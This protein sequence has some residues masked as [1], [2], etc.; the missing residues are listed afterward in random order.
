MTFYVF[1]L[2]HE[3]FK[4]SLKNDCLSRLLMKSKEKEDA[5][6]ITNKIFNFVLLIEK[7]KMSFDFFLIN[8]Q[9]PNVIHFSLKNSSEK[10]F[11]KF[12]VES[13]FICENL[14][15]DGNQSLF[16]YL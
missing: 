3:I 2:N 16:D 1:L 15:Y 11:S 14:F 9:A 13:N 12:Y 10:Y 5:K 7:W 6:K 4:K 8:S